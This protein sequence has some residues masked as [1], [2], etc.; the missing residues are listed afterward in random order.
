MSV[1]DWPRRTLVRLSRTGDGRAYLV[2]VEPHQ[3]E[4][5]DRLAYFEFVEEVEMYQPPPV[6]TRKVQP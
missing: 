3:A 1:T 5:G 4:S 2:A 6:F